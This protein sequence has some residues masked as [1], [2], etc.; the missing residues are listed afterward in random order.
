MFSYDSQT[1]RSERVESENAIDVQ[2]K[3]TIQV[4]QDVYTLDHDKSQISLTRISDIGS[5]RPIKTVMKG[6]P[7]SRGFPALCVFQNAYI[8]V[9]GG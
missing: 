1:K 8:F 2:E 9:S 3:F 7:S 6:P 5:G 4:L